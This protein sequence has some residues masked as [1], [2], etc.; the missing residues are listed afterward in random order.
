[1]RFNAFDLRGLRPGLVVLL[2]LALAGVVTRPLEN[3]AWVIVRA[4]QPALRLES[5]QGALG[6]GVTAGLLGGFRAIVAD[7][8]WIRA[9]VGWADSD[10]PAT[11]TLIKLVTT[12]DPRPQFFWINGANII[13]YDMPHWRIIEAGGYEVVP[14]SEQ[15][16]FDREQA[17][18]ALRLLKEGFVYHP[19]AV[20][21]YVCQANIQLN[22]SKD[23]AAAAESYRLAA[24]QPGAPYFA[25]RVYG[26][27]LRR[28]GRKQE[29]YLWLKQLYPTLPKA[30]DLGRAS[31]AQI[32]MAMADIVLGRIRELE[33]ELHIPESQSV[34]P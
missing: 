4:E 25:A 23:I 34:K 32:E 3:P 24:L 33:K 1:M 15:R 18:L 11:Q 12:I 16:R 21:L 6:Q 22:R 7:F 31:P 14:E 19:H 29:A 26:E 28:M 8:F 9:N 13:A 10:L 17:A 20:A 27:L 2:V 30:S 5:I